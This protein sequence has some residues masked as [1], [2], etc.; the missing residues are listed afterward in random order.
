MEGERRGEVG[1]GR[2]CAW[3]GRRRLV[4]GLR[5]GIWTLFF[6]RVLEGFE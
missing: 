2:G 6:G 5:E 1:V 4:L 3:R